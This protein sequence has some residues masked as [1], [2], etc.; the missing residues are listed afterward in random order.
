MN[1]IYDNITIVL[2]VYIP[3][4]NF[5][6]KQINLFSNKFK[7]VIVDLSPQKF[8]I[9][10]IIEDEKNTLIIDGPNNG[11]GYGHN[12]A[13]RNI[14]TKYAL[15]VD[16]DAEIDL[17]KIKKLYSYAEKIKD[18]SILVAN[19]NNK[20]TNKRLA[21]I[22]Q[23]DASVMLY[24][25]NTIKKY[26]MF[27]EKI[28]LYFEEKEYFSR[29]NKTNNKVYII[30]KVIV[31]HHQG[32]SSNINLIKNLKNLQQWHYLWSMFYVNKKMFGF[33]VSLKKILPLVL[34]DFMKM[35]YYFLQFKIVPTSRRASRLSGAF[36]SILGFSSFK[37]P[38]F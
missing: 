26:P 7:I 35:I 20:I 30:P 36:L 6:H 2:V 5:F 19:T 33:L 34:V 28:F 12:L 24:N 23:C 8:K 31:N 38:K 25:I 27:D 9:K 13:L 1:Q 11:Q 15:Y 29:L 37:R 17:I 4:L 10:E 16:I 32:S 3:D 21:I 18:F 22:E 14:H